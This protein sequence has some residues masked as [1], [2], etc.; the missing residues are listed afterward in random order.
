[1]SERRLI[2]LGTASQV[3]ARERNQ[4]GYFLRFDDEGLLFDP[5]EGTQRQMIFSGVS[6]T[7][8]TRIFI[9]H[10]HGD[11]CLGLAG[12][13]QRVS[14]DRVPHPIEIYYPASGQRYY[15]NLRDACSY[16]YAAHLVE[17][18]I[19]KDGRIFE[20]ERIF[21]EA[22]RLDHD[23]ETY[24]FRLEEKDSYTLIPRRLR[25]E[26]IAGDTAG[27][28]KR[29]GHV[30]VGGKTVRIEDVGLKMPG[31]V[32]AYIMDTRL[33]R[34]V[35]DLA[36]GADMLL[37]EATFLSDLEEKAREYG[38][39]TAAQAG[40]VA[41]DCG[42]KLLVISHYSQRYLTPEALVQEAYRFH[43]L[44]VAAGDGDRIDLPRRKRS[45]QEETAR[46]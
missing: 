26:G 42:V 14:L 43:P 19:S 5:G 21:I 30:R 40:Q 34:A 27:R 32:F 31:Q 25:E 6:V 29:E 46:G 39:L 12:I 7:G 36:S 24:G 37:M 41:R 10:F 44:S 3:P 13:I 45:G 15:E 23:I 4:N 16:H 33:C 11:H 28:L 8:I 22:R 17:R 38:H 20:N 2:V 9:S 18:P 35:F 1:M